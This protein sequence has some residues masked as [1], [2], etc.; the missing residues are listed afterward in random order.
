MRQPWMNMKATLTGTKVSLMIIF[1]AYIRIAGHRRGGRAKVTT[2]RARTTPTDRSQSSAHEPEKREGLLLR[3]TQ[4][5]YAMRTC[6]TY[7]VTTGR[8]VTS[9][10]TMRNLV[11][12]RSTIGAAAHVGTS[13]TAQAAAAI[14]VKARVLVARRT[15]VE[16]SSNTRAGIEMRDA[17]RVA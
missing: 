12:M 13:M 5:A 17:K 16:S 9:T 14:N 1:L 3:I 8:T 6:M 7:T 2:Q 10:K 4:L 11:H 15:V